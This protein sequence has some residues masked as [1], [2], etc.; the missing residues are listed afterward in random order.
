MRLP[1]GRLA[2]HLGL[3]LATVKKTARSEASDEPNQKQVG[4][5]HRRHQQPCRDERVHQETRQ[6]VPSFFITLSRSIYRQGDI[7]Y[8]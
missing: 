1:M 3:S 5:K 2:R 6:R 7:V 8:K 4:A